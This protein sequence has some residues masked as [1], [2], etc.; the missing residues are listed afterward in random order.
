MTRTQPRILET[1]LQN[2]EQL[3]L[4]R[5]NN[6]AKELAAALR[7]STN[8]IVDPFDSLGANHLIRRFPNFELRTLNSHGIILSKKEG[9]RLIRELGVMGLSDNALNHELTSDSYMQ[10][11]NRR[12]SHYNGTEKLVFTYAEI[13]Y[14]YTRVMGKI[15][16][17]VLTFPI[18]LVGLANEGDILF[19]II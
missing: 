7:I 14:F 3:I 8:T 11:F 9:C 1:P 13:V 18:S 2:A 15:I 6:L 10:T 17:D 12:A 19:P 5:G 16:P 4:Q